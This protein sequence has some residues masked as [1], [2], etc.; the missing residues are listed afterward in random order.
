MLANAVTSAVERLYVD[1]AVAD[2][3]NAVSRVGRVDAVP[4]IRPIT[5]GET[6]PENRADR[7]SNQQRQ[8]L[9]RG[10][11]AVF[12]A[13]TPPGGPVS[14]SDTS[15]VSSAEETRR[16]AAEEE[17]RPP[18]LEDQP[19]D[20]VLEEAIQRFIKT[21]FRSLAAAE[22]AGLLPPFDQVGGSSASSSVSGAGS[23]SSGR[24]ALS[25]RIGA[26][27]QRLANSPI[28]SRSAL[29]IGSPAAP[30][31]SPLLPAVGDRRSAADVGAPLDQ[32]FA[33]V[34]QV[35]KGNLGGGEASSPDTRTELVSLMKRLAVA[36]QG[37]PPHDPGLPTRGGLL[38]ERA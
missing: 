36:M 2:D 8:A 22:E 16:L 7:E 23:A 29:D 21:M 34:M 24:G 28:G 35:L 15:L 14:S 1:T 37:Q 5:E 4:R 17:E 30:G 6:K 20:P 3:R 27:A 31:S 25:A 12:E 18:K 10:V 26:L 33:E 32:A 13:G 11:I 38:S 19:P 9:T